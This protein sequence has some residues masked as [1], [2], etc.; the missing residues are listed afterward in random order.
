MHIPYKAVDD[1]YNLF[2]HSSVFPAFLGGRTRKALLN[3]ILIRIF[4]Q[5]GCLHVSK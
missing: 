3:D 1:W 5:I 2:L 4:L